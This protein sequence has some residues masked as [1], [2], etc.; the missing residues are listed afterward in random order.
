M[1]ARKA[2]FIFSLFALC[3]LISGLTSGQSNAE[4]KDYK[5]VYQSKVGEEFQ[6]FVFNLNSPSTVTKL[7]SGKYGSLHP[8]ITL[9]GK[10]IYYY[11]WT[12]TSWGDMNLMYYMDLVD[13]KEWLVQRNAVHEEND[14]NISPD[15]S[16]LGYRARQSVTT[17]TGTIPLTENWEINCLRTDFSDA[18]RITQTKND[19]SDPCLNKDGSKVYFAI[20][21]EKTKPKEEEEK[22]KE[23]KEEKKSSADS[24]TFQVAAAD[25]ENLFDQN[26][27]TM[28]L[29]FFVMYPQYAQGGTTKAET[30]EEEKKE[31]KKE[32]SEEEEDNTYLYYYIFRNSFDGKNLERI[33]PREYSAWHPSVDSKEKWMVFVSN[34]DG[35][36]EIYLMNLETFDV[37]RLTTNPGYDGV[38]H[39]SSDGEVIV[40]VSDRDGDKEVFKIDRDGENLV[41]LTDNTV[42]DDN[43]DIN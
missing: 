34:M 42:D 28:N 26:P 37:K 33:T 1:M 41:Q 20:A 39:I 21:V 17:E 18:K 16:T 22:G 31:S 32:D 29:P 14:P 4:T 9:N 5:I 35:D 23:K 43:P 7:T 38:P 24:L 40:F 8:T 11:H 27:G 19:E 12:P 25:C 36:E 10:R 13:H 15:G 30:L 6:I 2:T 3:V